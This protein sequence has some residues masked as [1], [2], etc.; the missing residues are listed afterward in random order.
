MKGTDHCQ[1]CG[2]LRSPKGG[3][4]RPAQAASLPHN[5]I[6]STPRQTPVARSRHAAQR[7]V[8]RIDEEHAAGN[9]GSRSAHRSAVGLHAVDRREIAQRVEVP[10]HRAVRCVVGAQMAVHRAG[11]DHARNQRGG[12]HLRGVHPRVPMHLGSGGGAVP[13]FLAGLDAQREQPATDLGS[14]PSMGPRMV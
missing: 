8:S 4:A 3:P 14:P 1:E 10:D 7:T 12:G 11:K 13:S 9:H 5:G 6:R 2:G